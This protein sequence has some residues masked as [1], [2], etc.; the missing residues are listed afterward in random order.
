MRRVLMLAVLLAVA[1]TTQRMGLAS[2]YGEEIPMETAMI[3]Y[4]IDCSCS[5]D[6][7][8]QTFI[9]ENGNSVSGYRMDRAK[10]EVIGSVNELDAEFRFDVVSFV[11]CQQAAFGRLEEGS[12][13]HKRQ[14]AG[15]IGTLSGGGNLGV[16]PA[17][18]WALQ[19]PAYAEVMEYIVV[20]GGRPTC[21]P[22]GAARP[23]F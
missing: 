18:A 11:R 23:L 9:D 13:E 1:F 2:I 14:A 21:I 5:M 10:S 3:V 22:D 16:G 8:W 17:V 19:N 15:W 7:Q 6:S 12:A 4:V 20:T